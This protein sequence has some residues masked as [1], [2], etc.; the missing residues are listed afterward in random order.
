MTGYWSVL[1]LRNGTYVRAKIIQ[2]LNNHR[3]YLLDYLNFQ[4][5][6][7]YHEPLVRATINDVVIVQNL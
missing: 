2:P 1:V 4:S 7:W 3:L 6:K 5:N